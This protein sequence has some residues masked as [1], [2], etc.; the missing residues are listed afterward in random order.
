VS[1]DLVNDP[2][3]VRVG[4]L[5]G[6]FWTQI[7]LGPRA[8]LKNVLRGIQDVPRGT[9]TEF[10]AEL[11]HLSTMKP[12]HA[13]F[14]LQWSQLRAGLQ[15]ADLHAVDR[16]LSVLPR[17]MDDGQI[18]LR[19]I[20]GHSAGQR[21]F[22]LL[23]GVTWGSS[24]LEDSTQAMLTRV[25]TGRGNL[26]VN[27]AIV[28]CVQSFINANPSASYLVQSLPYL[29]AA[30][31]EDAEDDAAVAL[32]M[33]W[34]MV[35]GLKITC[36]S[37]TSLALLEAQSRND[38][39][40]HLHSYS[41]VGGRLGVEFDLPGSKSRLEGLNWTEFGFHSPL[42]MTPL[43]WQST[44]GPGPKTSWLI[45]SGAANE[46][47]WQA[48]AL[49]E[50][51]DLMERYG[52]SDERKVHAVVN[53]FDPV[54]MGAFMLQGDKLRRAGYQCKP[55]VGFHGSPEYVAILRQ[56]FKAA[57]TKGR[58]SGA[59]GKIYGTGV[60]VDLTGGDQGI[61]TTNQ[62]GAVKDDNGR[63]KDT[64][65]SV[66]VM[67]WA[68]TL[69]LPQHSAGISTPPSHVLL[70][71]HK[72][73]WVVVPCEEN[74]VPVGFVTHMRKGV[75]PDGTAQAPTPQ[76]VI[77]MY[78]SSTVTISGPTDENNVPIQVPAWMQANPL[79]PWMS[80]S[81]TEA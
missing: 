62:Y 48:W 10:I 24:V 23:D 50:V 55:M 36:S 67:F 9:W 30:D 7:D 47:D 4:E 39:H 3:V 18:F 63:V 60:Y 49:T 37:E 65:V 81:L 68:S 45:S 73:S 58:P 11:E 32:V 21:L 12:V 42:E 66:L 2:G 29:E 69:E 77:A 17:L 40:V 35:R 52:C 56:G 19:C 80:L 57:E 76:S 71:G 43:P 64:N 54:K 79:T 28:H 6:P 16:V 20:A 5:L 75:V 44:P 31:A 14:M 51:T 13:V 1:D 46:T 61:G 25:L 8:F 78:N 22:A 26:S 70:C 41:R 34:V 27:N 53:M 72:L 15:E 74:T 59:R 33:A 38:A